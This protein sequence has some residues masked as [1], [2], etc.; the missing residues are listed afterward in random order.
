MAIKGV[1]KRRDFVA[2]RRVVI[3]CDHDIVRNYCFHWLNVG[4]GESRRDK[5]AVVL[6]SGWNIFFVIILLF[7][8]FISTTV[9]PPLTWYNS[10]LST[11]ATIF[12]RQSIHWLPGLYLGFIVWRRSPKWPKAM[13]FPGGSGACPPRNFLKWICTEV[14]SGALWDSMLRNVTVF[15]LTSSCPD[16]FS[17]IVSY[18]YTVMRTIFSWAF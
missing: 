5:C 14:Q 7:S 2:G 17:H 9:Q 16:D 11:T 15:A 8:L 18:L 12:G 3:V 10:H 1:Q 4:S 13:S 6:M